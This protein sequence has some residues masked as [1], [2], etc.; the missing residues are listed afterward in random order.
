MAGST[1]V[2]VPCDFEVVGRT[3]NLATEEPHAQGK[4]GERWEK[5]EDME[6]WEKD[7]PDEGV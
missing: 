7:T 6:R 3:L 1:T 2:L 5:E 4:D